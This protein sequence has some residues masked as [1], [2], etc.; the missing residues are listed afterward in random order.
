MS[1]VGRTMRW[2]KFVWNDWQK[3]EGLKMCSLAARGLWMEML[4]IMHNAEPRGYLLVNGR[5]PTARQMATLVGATEAE[6]LALV[7]ELREAGVYSVREDG[8]PF[9]R[10]MR[11]EVENEARWREYGARG[12]N[13]NITKNQR[14]ADGVNPYAQ[15]GLTPTV[16]LESESEN[17]NQKKESPLPPASG[18]GTI[19]KADFRKG[20]RAEQGPVTKLPRRTRDLALP[21]HA[22]A[23]AGF[24]EFWRNYPK[25]R[26]VK[27]PIALRAWNSALKRTGGDGRVIIDGLRAR[28]HTEVFNPKNGPSFIPHPS[29]WLNADGWNDPV[30]GVDDDDAAAAGGG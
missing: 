26:R 16:N 18:G 9:S 10:R 15:G 8:V 11:D 22:D 27:K 28:L 2:S 1:K 7:E 17:K 5:K 23:L 29:S 30:P 21:E 20:K 24:E 12:G 25:D 3:D 19:I 13:P 4:C 14:D 6:I